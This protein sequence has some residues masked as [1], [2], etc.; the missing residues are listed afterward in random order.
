MIEEIGT[1][2]SFGLD[3]YG[4]VPH[5]AN[6]VQELREEARV[7][8]PKLAGATV[9]MVN[10]A[11]QGG[12]VAEMLPRVVGLLNELGVRTRWAVIGSDRADF[13]SLTKHIHNL[14]HGSGDPALS[15]QDRALYDQ[16]SRSLADELAPQIAP[17]DVLA[18]HDPQPAGMGR[19]VKEKTGVRAIWR[20]HIGVAEDTPETRAAWDFL[21]PHVTPYD[22]A[23]FSA[24]EYIPRYLGAAVSIIHPGLD[25][26]S[27]KNRD[28]S[29]HKLV[30]ILV[31]AK[32]L[33]AYGPVIAPPFDAP[34]ARLQPDG[35][36]RPAVEPEDIGLL[37]RPIV[38][39]VSRWDRLKGFRP[40]LE[41][42]VELKSNAHAWAGRYE[43][44]ERR[45]LEL[46]RLV[47][48]G[49]DPLSIQDDPE[50]VEV[51]HEICRLYRGLEPALQKDVVILSLPMSSLKHNALMVNALQRC[52][53]LIVQN[54]LREGFG[55]TATE[56]MWK[57]VAVVASNATGLRQQIRHGIDGFLVD[58]PEDST[59][60]AHALER[61]LSRPR[62]REDFGRHAQRRVHSEFLVFTQ[63]RRWLRVLAQVVDPRRATPSP[64]A[65]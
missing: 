12:G 46:V 11:A 59:V 65:G 23:I 30:G 28:L 54:S 50:A 21:Q 33:P 56:G 38:T 4:A 2:S 25:P 7:L 29:T 35:S 51:F 17:N 3:D 8:A 26:F 57:R 39:Q 60:I 16:V 27:H 36:F 53:T 58:N 1:R 24:P 31:D 22:H 18:V 43:G 45:T 10:S 52:A 63:L 15:E 61:L 5:L 32:L 37:F 48:A 9:W 47:L 19:F 49:P 6:A 14:I 20:C 55:L 41:A 44:R 42:F 40:L 64:T 62:E 13:F 34:A